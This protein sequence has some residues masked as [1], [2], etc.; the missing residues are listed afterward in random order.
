M[1]FC[2][3]KGEQQRLNR[4]GRSE[5]QKCIREKKKVIKIRIRNRERIFVEIKIGVKNLRYKMHRKQHR[6][7]VTK[8]C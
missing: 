7:A 2:I 1:F 8:I 3:R 5:G 4:G 6:L